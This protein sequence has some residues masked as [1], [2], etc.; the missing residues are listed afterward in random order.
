MSIGNWFK[1]QMLT[2][3]IALA[4][5]EKNAL[6]QGGETLSDDANMIQRHRQGMLSDDLMQ[7]KITE[8]VITLRARMYRIL[9]ESQSYSYSDGERGYKVDK[10]VIDRKIKG[11]PSDEYKVELVVDNEKIPV[12][13]ADATEYIDLPAESPII[14][15]RDILPKFKLE[16]YANKLYVKTI[17]GDSK[18]LE[19][20]LNK[21]KDKYDK[22]TGFLIND[23]KKAIKNPRTSDL[24]DIK[25]VGFVSYNTIGSQDFLE[26]Q[27]DDIVFDKI[28]EYNGCYV[29]KFKCKVIV[30]GDSVTEK[31][32][33]E[34]LDK[35][36]A[37]KEKR[38]K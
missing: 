11:E 9:E 14:I 8:E 33:D 27:Y 18:L 30:D 26:Y 7:G 2:F 35:R 36:Y 15:G 38:N 3:S 19:F 31:Y 29:I 23:I 12:D 16:T 34:E 10:T 4:N 17:D 6:G 32:S 13:F 24:L 20:H 28:V 25:Q 22:K 5:V 37:N 1:N 21:Y